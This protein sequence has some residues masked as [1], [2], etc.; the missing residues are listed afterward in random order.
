MPRHGSE[1]TKE[2]C[3]SA[4]GS[5]DVGSFEKKLEISSLGQRASVWVSQVLSGAVVAR[6]LPN[7]FL[8]RD[9]S[10]KIIIQT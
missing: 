2:F 4:L 1:S 9:K 3:N 8:S 5:I 10:S 6:V 7:A